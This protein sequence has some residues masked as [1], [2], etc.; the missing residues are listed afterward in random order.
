MGR[1]EKIG[2]LEVGGKSGSRSWAEHLWHARD[3]NLY[4]VDQDLFERDLAQLIR[5]WVLPGHCPPAPFLTADDEVITLG[6]CFARNLRRMLDKAGVSASRFYIPSGLNN[7]FALLDLISW[8]VTGEETARGFRYDRMED[9]A[10][11]DWTPVDEREVYRQALADAGAFVFTLGLAEV[12]EDR[13]TGGVF[14]RG[15]PESVF[16]ADRHVSRLSTVGEN[17]EN[18]ARLVE[19]IR[20]VNPTA[21]IVVTL[22]PVPLKATFRPISCIT[23]DCAS[24]ATLRV[25]IDQLM[26]RGLEGV[27]YWPAFEVVRWV[28][29][30]LPYPV[31][32]LG[33]SSRRP[34]KEIVRQI[35]SAFIEAFWLPDAAI[36]LQTAALADSADD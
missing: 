4:P 27:Y 13:E 1:G 30:N 12:W 20:I 18:M 5:E 10:I 2:S 26:N 32:G 35:V 19:L 34:E 25:A 9:G 23:A 6:S 7:T 22:S 24:K 21:P 8:C 15:I 31:Y 33:G 29:A 28:G 3:V 36:V 11:R 16:D 14:W 17:D